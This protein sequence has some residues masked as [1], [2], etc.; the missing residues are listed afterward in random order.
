MTGS[1]AEIKRLARMIVRLERN[2]LALS[3]PQLHR[4]S[5]ENGAVREYE[6]SES[7]TTLGSQMGRQFDGTHVAASINGPTPPTPTAPA[8][9]PA[10]GGLLVHWDGLWLEDPLYPGAPVIV[11][12]DFSRIEIHARDTITP[13]LFDALGADTLQATIE[14][15]R[16]CTVFIGLPNE[17]SYDVKLITRTFS[18]GTGEPSGAATGTPLPVVDDLVDDVEQLIID[19]DAAEED[20]G[21]IEALLAGNLAE[22][23]TLNPSTDGG[24]LVTAANYAAMKTLLTLVVGTDVMP[25]TANLSTFAG[26]TGTEVMAYRNSISG[27][28]WVTAA[29]TSVARTLLD[30][31]TVTG[32][33]NTLL[34]LGIAPRVANLSAST[35]VID[36][37]STA[38]TE[39]AIFDSGW[40]AGT[41][42][43]TITGTPAEGQLLSV[44][45]VPLAVSRA[46]VWSTGFADVNPAILPANSVVSKHTMIEFRYNG[47]LSVFQPFSVRV[48]A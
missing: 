30:D 46:L 9:T 33:R 12:M 27:G 5:I 1:N 41:K 44:R 6:S 3:V 22:W 11:P 42:T 32:M 47:T 28:T 20:I 4:S 31:T 23:A 48:Q 15:P 8:V 16:G 17:I 26:L 13:G 38:P 2:M 45:L 10:I 25:Y 7:G 43:F 35:G 19:M 40:G 39:L 14:T 18:G 29:L 37:T 24:N 36:V 21:D 34:A